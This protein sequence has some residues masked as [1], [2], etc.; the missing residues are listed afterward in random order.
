MLLTAELPSD[1]REKM[2]PVIL[3]VTKYTSTYHIY[4]VVHACMKSLYSCETERK[5]RALFDRE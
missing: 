4:S 1:N 2:T 3:Y 5:P